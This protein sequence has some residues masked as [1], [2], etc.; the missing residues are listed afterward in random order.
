[1]YQ[2]ATSLT[3]AGRVSARSGK[4]R[5]IHFT[6]EC[7]ELFKLRIAGRSAD[8]VMFD[9]MEM[10][11]MYRNRVVR[12]GSPAQRQRSSRQS[13]SIFSG[14]S[15]FFSP[16]D[17]LPLMAIAQNLD[18][19]D[20]RMVEKLYGHLAPSYRAEQIQAKAPRFRMAAET[21]VMPLAD[22]ERA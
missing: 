12:C 9:R 17:G 16:M 4:T 11:G 8:A 10:D 22:R 5:H 6:D 2:R 21:N 14:T 1:M 3:S 18:N 7:A 13:H 15:G 20:A 19:A